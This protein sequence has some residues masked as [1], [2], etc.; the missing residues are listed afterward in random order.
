MPYWAKYWTLRDLRRYAGRHGVQKAVQ[1]AR[2]LTQ[3]DS[4]ILLAAGWVPAYENGGE[5]TIHK[6]PIKPYMDI[7]KW[8]GL[9]PPDLAAID[10]AITLLG[11]DY[12]FRSLLTCPWRPDREEQKEDKKEEV[13]EPSSGGTPQE[14][15]TEEGNKEG[16]DGQPRCGEDAGEGSKEASGSGPTLGEIQREGAPDGG[17]RM[18]SSPNEKG[19]MTEGN[20]TPRAD[21]IGAVSDTTQCDAGSAAGEMDANGESPNLAEK[22]GGGEAASTAPTGYAFGG[23]FAKIKDEKSRLKTRASAEVARALKRLFSLWLGGLEESPRIDGRRLVRE[24]ISKRYQISRAK[25]REL[26]TGTIL[27]MADVS[28]SCSAAAPQTIAA[29]Q[30]VALELD[31]VILIVHS[32]G[33]PVEVMTRDGIF[34]INIDITR[35]KR[36]EVLNWWRREMFQKYHLVGAINFGDW[37]AGDVL[38]L[39]SAQ[40]PLV[41]LDSYAAIAGPKPVHRHSALRDQMTWATPPIVWWQGVIDIGSAAIAL[42]AAVRAITKK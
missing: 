36:A 42:R 37:D 2:A 32:N 17:G 35:W 11:P 1:K 40:C 9:I 21:T 31:R 34:G 23:V 6:G 20:S 10:R 16:D 28:G 5:Y 8:W 4:K 29:C 19:E 30:Q 38:E 15:S 25:R 14:E 26:E 27:L 22:F 39:I 12:E 41:W 13:I 33:C 3:K 7:L 24:L 18:E